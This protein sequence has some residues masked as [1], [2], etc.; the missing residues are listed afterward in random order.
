MTIENRFYVWIAFKTIQNFFQIK[1]YFKRRI[2]KNTML[3]RGKPSYNKISCKGKWQVK[4]SN[5][6]NSLSK[7]IISSLHL[8]LSNS[9]MWIFFLL[10]LLVISLE[11]NHTFH[12]KIRLSEYFSSFLFPYLF[13]AHHA[14]S[15]TLFLYWKLIHLSLNKNKKGTEQIFC[16]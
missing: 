12:W 11:G 10:H 4:N 16:F 5:I 8:Y 7:R 13:M 15:F 3:F 14:S 9:F 6:R 1:P 2:W